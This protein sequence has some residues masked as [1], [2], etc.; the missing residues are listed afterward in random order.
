[1]KKIICFLI[2]LAVIALG[3]AYSQTNTSSKY[4]KGYI[5]KQ[6]GT[7]VQPHYKTTANKTNTDNYS[8]K[9]NTN[10]Y[11]GAKGSKAQDYSNS[12]KNYG[13]GK[14][15]TTGPKGG[16]SYKTNS[17]AKVYVPKR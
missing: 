7:Y 11:T 15:V 17:G 6:S 3:S 16:Q 8:T 9:G 14:T 4:Q 1:M 2:L 5:K 10:T 13:K 12:A